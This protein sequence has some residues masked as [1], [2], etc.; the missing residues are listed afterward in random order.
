MLVPGLFQIHH[1][2]LRVH[3]EPMITLASSNSFENHVVI[4]I[5]HLILQKHVSISRNAN[6]RK[7]IDSTNEK[8]TFTIVSRQSKVEREYSYEILSI[9]K[10][11]KRPL[12]F[13]NMKTLSKHSLYLLTYCTH[14]L[15]FIFNI[16]NLCV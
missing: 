13:H 10:S 16:S 5:L 8:S 2:M 4:I 15:C 12:K 9:E 7:I 11:Y 6:I 3:H 1:F 14:H